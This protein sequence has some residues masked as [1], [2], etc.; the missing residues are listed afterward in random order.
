MLVKNFLDSS[1]LSFMLKFLRH[2][3]IKC[4]FRRSCS[5]FLQELGAMMRS[6]NCSV[7]AWFVIVETIG[8][9]VANAVE[10]EIFINNRLIEINNIYA[11]LVQTQMPTP[12]Y[13]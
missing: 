5:A 3:S 4:I 12:C 2:R 6:F 9:A 8:T 11:T 13:F 10:V 7:T 1:L